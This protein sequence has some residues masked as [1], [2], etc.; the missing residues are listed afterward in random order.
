ME[1][2]YTCSVLE[3]CPG[4]WVTRAVEV[5]GKLLWVLLMTRR[6]NRRGMAPDQAFPSVSNGFNLEDLTASV[7]WHMWQG[8]LLLLFSKSSGSKM[9][10]LKRTEPEKPCRVA[11]PN[12]ASCASAD[13]RTGFT[14]LG[15]PRGHVARASC[16][17][18][19]AADG[20]TGG[21]ASKPRSQLWSLTPVLIFPF[22]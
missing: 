21:V 12:A 1:S 5:Q 2:H 10:L 14:R 11:S 16:E 18:R 15:M 13:G 22:A 17:V 3:Q 19:T 6:A 7:N 20:S 8:V 9:A 4:P